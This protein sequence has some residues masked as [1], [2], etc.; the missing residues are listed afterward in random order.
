MKNITF[1]GTG[2]YILLKKPVKP[3]DFVAFFDGI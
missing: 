3:I 2:Y 1:D